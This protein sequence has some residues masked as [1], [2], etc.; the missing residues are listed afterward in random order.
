M[1]VSDIMHKSV[2]SVTPS[3][4]LKEV[5]RMIFSLGINSIP[6]VENGK[7]VGL[8]TQEDILSLMYPTMQDVIEDY[9]HAAS[10]EKMEKNLAGILE[11]PVEKIM[12]KNVTSILPDLPLMQAQSL[13]LIHKFSHLPVVNEKQEL[14]GMISQGDIFRHIIR[15][16]MPKIEKESYAE[17]IADYYD[18]MVDWDKRFSYEFPVLSDLFR[19]EKVKKVL[20]L[21][22]WTGEYTVRF[23]KKGNYQILGVDNHQI[24]IDMAEKKRAELPEKIKEN[25]RFELVNYNNFASKI[26]KKFDAAIC[27][28]NSL[29]YIPIKPIDLCKQVS[30]V[31]REDGAIVVLQLLNFQKV[32]EENNRLLS[33]QIQ[34]SKSPNSKEHIFSEFIDKKED[35]SLLHHVIIFDNDGENWI[36]KGITT[37]PVNNVTK[38]DLEK[39]LRKSG[40]TDI[41]FAGNEGE[42]QDEYGPLNFVRPFDPL[43]SDWLNVVAKRW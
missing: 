13:I 31:L 8:V 21:G 33:F 34:P 4:P 16:E 3:T 20:D 36:F 14:L 9:I 2:F 42:Y 6:V 27:M 12:N 17:F 10:F 11:V 24:M 40:F 7:L 19:R 30:S 1:K 29:P 32:L 37:I 43:K 39:V 22:V 15:N 18:L 26:K 23:A 41:I 28:G 5:G 25:L 35:G 38:E